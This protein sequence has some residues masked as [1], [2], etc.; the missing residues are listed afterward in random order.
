MLLRK[1]MLCKN[2]IVH[3]ICLRT[4]DLDNIFFPRTLELRKKI[5]F[6]NKILEE[7]LIRGFSLK[8]FC[9]I[10]NHWYLLYP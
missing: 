10:K 2:Y 3:S 9:Q 6:S 4:F 5:S 8:N 7:S 1:N